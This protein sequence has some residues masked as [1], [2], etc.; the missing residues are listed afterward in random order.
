MRKK[1]I[2]KSVNAFKASCDAIEAFVAEL[3][4]KGLADQSVS[5]GY[6]YAIIR[7]YREFESLILDCIVASINNDTATLSATTGVK[8]PKHLT[9]EVCEYIVIGD[10]YFDF[11]G[12]DGLIKT[13]KRFV[14]DAHFLITVTKNAKYRNCLEKLSALRN[15]AAHESAQAKGRVLETVNQ[16]RIGAGGAWLKTQGRLEAITDDLRSFASELEKGAPY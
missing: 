2:K 6:D 8:F 13:L 4:S 12:R 7:L 16:K 9:D 5:W 11:R 1:S 15:Y 10:G 3:E 14:P